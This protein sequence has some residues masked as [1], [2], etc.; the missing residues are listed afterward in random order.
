VGTPVAGS[1]V[2]GESVGLRVGVSVAITP[3]VV[4]TAVWAEEEHEKILHYSA[5]MVTISLLS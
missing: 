2:G 5:V 4:G 3:S 1:R